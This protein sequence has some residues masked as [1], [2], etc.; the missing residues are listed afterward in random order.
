[1][2]H[3]SPTR[4]ANAHISRVGW[5]STNPRRHLPLKESRM[6]L[7]SRANP[8]K[9]STPTEAFTSST[10]FKLERTT[11]TGRK[12]S[13]CATPIQ[14]ENSSP[15]RMTGRHRVELVT[16]TVPVVSP[17]MVGRIGPKKRTTLESRC[18]ILDLGS[19]E[20]PG[21][22]RFLF[23][24]LVLLTEAKPFFKFEKARFNV[25]ITSLSLITSAFASSALLQAIFSATVWT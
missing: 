25:M 10:E 4:S 11:A 13:S 14:D 2:M 1:M 16:A 9:Q 22:A 3:S 7:T 8:T 15:Q 19:S 24:V 17:R 23:H 21:V 20:D 6:S 5:L 12:C 18:L